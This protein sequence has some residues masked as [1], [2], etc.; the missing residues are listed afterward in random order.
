V[1]HIADPNKRVEYGRTSRELQ[2]VGS[3]AELRKEKWVPFTLA[4]VYVHARVPFDIIARF[5][6]DTNIEVDMHYIDFE[7]QIINEPAPYNAKLFVMNDE[8]YH[9]FSDYLNN[10][11]I[12]HRDSQSYC[13]MRRFGAP[14]LDPLMRV[15]SVEQPTPQLIDVWTVSSMRGTLLPGGHTEVL[16]Y[17]I[18]RRGEAEELT[19][20]EFLRRLP[21]P[22][23]APPSVIMTWHPPDAVVVRTGRIRLGDIT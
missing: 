4:P 13:I 2:L 17:P 14:I 12:L 20:E 18:F 16:P 6:A 23:T 21:P 7:F 8:A 3:L 19:R 15:T 22:T 9:H 11:E 5:C 1:R 10:T